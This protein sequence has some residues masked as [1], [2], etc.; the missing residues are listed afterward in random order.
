[1]RLTICGPSTAA[2]IIAIVLVGFCLTA[3]PVYGINM[4]VLNNRTVVVNNN[5]P[6]DDSSEITMLPN[7]TFVAHAPLGT[8]V[9]PVHVTRYPNGDFVATAHFGPVVKPT[10]NESSSNSMGNMTDPS[11]E[12]STNATDNQTDP[13]NATATAN[14]GRIIGDTS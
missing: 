7:G 11:N 6:G 12:S 9:S 1:M 8:A 3:Q 2:V 4:G 5:P 14:E 13:S 10:D